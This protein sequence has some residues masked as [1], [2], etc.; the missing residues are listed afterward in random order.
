MIIVYRIVDKRYEREALTGDGAKEYPGRWN[1]KGTPVVYASA[2]RALA[3]LELFVHLGDEGKDKEYVFIPLIIPDFLAITTL[4]ANNLLP[5]W[6]VDPVPSYTQNLGGKWIA[7]GRTAILKVPSTV[8]PGDCNYV[9]N[10]RHPDF[11]EVTTLPAEPFFYDP[12]MW[13]K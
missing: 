12:R 1:P 4:T 10:V 2:S 7:R 3:V 5:G 9:L 6:N 8:V 11:A 13:G